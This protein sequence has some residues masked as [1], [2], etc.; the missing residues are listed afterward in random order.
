MTCTNKVSY[1]V[2][3]GFD[4]RETFV[5]CGSTDPYGDRAVC[6]H[7]AADAETMRHIEA[8]E[9]DIKADNAAA[10][11]AGWGDF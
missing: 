1:W 9:A 2:P 10:R 5:R 3:R 11:S 7:C 6:E 4:Y 8:I